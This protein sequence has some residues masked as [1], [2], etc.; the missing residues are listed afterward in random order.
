ME[1]FGRT[2]RSFGTLMRTIAI[3]SAAERHLGKREL[4]AVP[5]PNLQL[6]AA[7]T[8]EMFHLVTSA[9]HLTHHS[10]RMSRHTNVDALLL[11]KVGKAEGRNG[12]WDGQTY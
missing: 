7:G 9:A 8:A 12:S 1:L 3:P 6:S 5:P 2:V 10:R 4:P 11:W